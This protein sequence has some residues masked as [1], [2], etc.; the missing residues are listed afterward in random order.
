MSNT[1]KAMLYVKIA[2]V[3]WGAW[4]DVLYKYLVVVVLGYFS[5]TAIISLF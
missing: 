1:T 3:K 5:I 4:I 2:E